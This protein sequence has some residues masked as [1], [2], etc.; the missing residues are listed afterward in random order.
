M[1][2]RNFDRHESWK[3]PTEDPGETPSWIRR[4]HIPI[5]AVGGLICVLI[6]WRRGWTPGA[7]ISWLHQAIAP[8]L[9]LGTT[10]TLSEWSWLAGATFLLVVLLDVIQC[11]AL[12]TDGTRT[13][14]PL[15]SR[16]RVALNL[17][18]FLLIAAVNGA[19]FGWILWLRTVR[20]GVDIYI[21]RQG[22][23]PV[24]SGTAQRTWVQWLID[25][26]LSSFAAAIYLLVV[27]RFLLYGFS[28]CVLAPRRAGFWTRAHGRYLF[29]EGWSRLIL[30]L[31]LI[32]NLISFIFAALTLIGAPQ[33]PG[34]AAATTAV[35]QAESA[36]S[37]PQPATEAGADAGTDT[38]P[39]DAELAALS[40]EESAPV[41]NE[42]QDSPGTTRQS[43]D[44]MFLLLC[45]A[46]FGLLV[47]CVLTFVVMPALEWLN[48]M[49]MGR[50]LIKNEEQAAPEEQLVRESVA[51]LNQEV[52]AIARSAHTL[53]DTLAGAQQLIQ[54]TQG[55]TEA[56]AG[57]EQRFDNLDA[58]L[59]AMAENVGTVARGLS[60]VVTKLDATADK[61]KVGNENLEALRAAFKAALDASGP[62]LK[63]WGEVAD[64]TRVT[65][66]ELAAVARCIQQPIG[67]LAQIVCRFE[68]LLRQVALFAARASE[69]RADE[70]KH[71]RHLKDA[72]DTLSQR[73]DRF[74][75]ALEQRERQAATSEAL[76]QQFFEEVKLKVEAQDRSIAAHAA[77]LPTVLERLEA[78]FA[79]LGTAL[80]EIKSEQRRQRAAIKDLRVR[81]RALGA[82][83]KSVTK[84]AAKPNR[85]ENHS[86]W[87][88]SLFGRNHTGNHTPSSGSDHT[89]TTE[90]Q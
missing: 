34:A 24:L 38:G 89:P 76:S 45:A 41:A 73:L 4:R 27:L 36:L 59:T 26:D 21:L 70:T 68:P 65:E 71:L 82:Q 1:T 50:H 81:T 28:H 69:E 47:A 63:A 87:A 83:V 17:M 6:L 33:E 32:G 42:G 2:S 15:L 75:R 66:G 39:E 67:L 29:S 10:W 13:T 5:A 86:R 23:S 11:R 62:A 57:V 30:Q 44:K 22:V 88:F 7:S 85:A 25:L 8:V 19:I 64:A 80:R 35:V 46:L 3:L 90:G 31:G 51:S 16:R 77:D 20:A 37:A 48:G 78:N 53:T 43:S 56:V 52:D 60:G 79:P 9:Y 18:R 58:T 40:S 74:S 55:A 14:P 49:A 12:A 54:A 84:R 61:L 72:F